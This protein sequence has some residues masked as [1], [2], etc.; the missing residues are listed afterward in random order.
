MIPN[1][2]LNKAINKEI[3]QTIALLIVS[4]AV[5]LSL[6]NPLTFPKLSSIPTPDTINNNNPKTIPQK[7]KHK[8][9]AR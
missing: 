1:A 7:Q 4:R 5:A 2:G 6:E 8:K 9:Q 3:P